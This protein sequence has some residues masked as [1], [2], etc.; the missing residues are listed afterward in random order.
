[1]CADQ[2]HPAAITVPKGSYG[3]PIDRSELADAIFSTALD[4]II[5]AD[6]AGQIVEWNAAAER[7]FGLLRAQV[8]GKPLAETIVPPH[9]RAAHLTGMARYL[10][11]AG[12]RMLGRRVETE[13]M[14]CDG[15]LFPAELTIFEARMSGRRVFAATLR[16]LSEQIQARQQLDET[17]IILQSVFD[18]VPAELYLRKLDGTIVAINKWGANLLRRTPEELIGQRVQDLR[19]P[20]EADAADAAQARLLATGEPVTQEFQIPYADR[21]VT[22]LNTMFPVRDIDGR[23]TQVGGIIFDIS[24][25]DRA[26]SELASA[27]ESL[28]Q[29]EK[30]AAMGRLLAGVA[31]ELNNPLAIVLGRA[32]MLHE[33]LAGTPHATSLQKLHDAAARCARIVRTFLAMARQTGPRRVPVLLGDLI[34][35]AL[36]ISQRARDEAGIALHLDLPRELPAI[37]ADEDQIVQVIMNLV[38]NACQALARHSGEREIAISAR[39]DRMRQEAE[40]TVADT[41]PGIPNDLAMQV[42]DPFFT[43]KDVG[44]G[45]GLGLPLCRSMIEA[46]GG[47]LILVPDTS[48]GATFRIRLPVGHLGE[49]QPASSEAQ[50]RAVG[51]VLVV[52]D[53]PELAAI[54]ADCL[55]PVGL[56]VEIA[57]DGA[58]ALALTCAFSFDAVFC[59]VRMPGMDGPAFYARLQETSPHLA[60]RLAFVSGDVLHRDWDQLRAMLNRPVIEKPFDP[61]IVRAVALELLG[62]KP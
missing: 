10:A 5:V 36:D 17:R 38:L 51:R 57:T 26:R 47:S 15:S 35:G 21:I 42:F 25:L 30:L 39:H 58:A 46:H 59:D 19:L 2:F 40:I 31:H 8:L 18:S 22:G 28:H 49:P 33:Q 55:R 3:S 34:R 32:S 27:R 11:G 9:L 16:D 45:T 52:D 50:A 13:G 44:E 48:R 62:E 56:S 54:L 24:E 60:R 6:E 41:G 29:A 43:T 14:R 53:E 23:I 37:E 61:N 1:M 12:A 20:S 4:S 7:T